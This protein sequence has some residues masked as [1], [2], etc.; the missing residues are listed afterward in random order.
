M[1]AVVVALVVVVLE[2][3]VAQVEVETV[4]MVA[5]L[6]TAMDSVEPQILAVVAVADGNTVYRLEGQADPAL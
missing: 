4:D 3:Q 2:F 5:H 1:L 6:Q